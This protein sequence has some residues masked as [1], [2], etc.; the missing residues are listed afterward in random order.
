MENESQ[1]G[2][3]QRNENRNA[4]KINQ[5]AAV[6][7]NAKIGRC[8]NL[9]TGREPGSARR[10]IPA[11]GGKSG[12]PEPW[13]MRGLQHSLLL[14]QGPMMRRP[15][16]GSRG[17]S[18]PLGAL[19]SDVLLA[20]GCARLP[21]LFAPLLLRPGRSLLSPAWPQCPPPAQPLALLCDAPDPSQQPFK[22]AELEDERTLP[23]PTAHPHSLRS[24][25]TA[26]RP[27][28]EAAGLLRSLPRHGR[29][30]RAPKGGWASARSSTH[31]QRPA[32]RAQTTLC[33]VKS[34]GQRPQC[35]P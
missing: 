10:Y 15:F 6:G 4:L 12:L 24:R 23:A 21:P 29:E 8:G 25:R 17:C 16:P 5:S 20:A 33:S 31:S 22:I 28:Q 13:V 14:W 27:R 30:T 26:A 11:Q 1:C 34:Q 2:S 32:T 7:H 18:V 35:P 19:P 9:R 3:R